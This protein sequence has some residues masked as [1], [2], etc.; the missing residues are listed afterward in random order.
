MNALERLMAQHN[1]GAAPSTATAAPVAQPTPP[2]PP[3]PL[4]PPPPPP[5]VLVETP[6]VEA[7]TQRIVPT[8]H[9]PAPVTALG[10]VPEELSGVVQVGN[11]ENPDEAAAFMAQ[12]M[13]APLQEFSVHDLMNSV[14]S[15]ATMSFSQPFAR[16]KEGNWEVLK[17]TDAAIMDA[18][19][20]GNRAFYA[21]YLAYRVGATGWRGAG[22]N[23]KGGSPPL[24]KFA[25]PHPRVGGMAAAKT[26]LKTMAVGSKVQFTKSDDR[27]KFDPVGRLTP[28]VHV[29]VWTPGAGFIILTTAG[30][31]SSRDTAES[32]AQV[33]KAMGMAH[34]FEI[35][36][37]DIENKKVAEGAK[38]KRWK[39][40]SIKGTLDPVQKAAD[41]T[42]AFKALKERDMVA[43]S[44]IIGGFVTAS[45][46]AG[47]LDFG[48]IQAKM[49][50]YE[51][52]GLVSFEA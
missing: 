34:K 13:G 26:I 25:I 37:K 4:P 10:K 40:Y 52:H 23:T 15:G 51:E 16:V 43:V 27:V 36:D 31:E 8:T 45:D 20:A 28:E 33:E 21:V 39:S 29:L 49:N 7:Q 35:Y 19:P 6:V 18:M 22:S 3:V 32:L 24:W 12:M 9:V 17:T 30:F 46:Y 44:K 38:N 5:P 14:D 47:G 48:Q 1:K 50:E 41:M 2:P 42:M 11:L